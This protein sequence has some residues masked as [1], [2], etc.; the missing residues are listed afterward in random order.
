MIFLLK[1]ASNVFGK[2]VIIIRSDIEFSTN[3]LIDYC[4]DDGIK[5]EMSAP[6]QSHHNGLVERW[7]RTITTKAMSLLAKGNVSDDL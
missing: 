5:H 6:Y 3:S 2:K 1:P 7:L 4:D